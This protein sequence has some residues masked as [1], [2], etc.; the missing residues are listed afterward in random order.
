[1][2]LNLYESMIH[3]DTCEIILQVSFR[4]TCLKLKLPIVIGADKGDIP[5][6]VSGDVVVEGDK[7]KYVAT[8]SSH[9]PQVIYILA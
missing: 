8:P 9:K 4:G 7:S 3:I 2:S 6:T 5:P 1:M